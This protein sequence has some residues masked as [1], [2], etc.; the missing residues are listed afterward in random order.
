MLHNAEADAGIGFNF[1]LQ[2]FGELLVV[3]SCDH[4]Q[5]IDIEASQTVAVLIDA[6]A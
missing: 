1:L 3:F 6:Q 4:G 2:I 5:R